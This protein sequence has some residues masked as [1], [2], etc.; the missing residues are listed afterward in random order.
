MPKLDTYKEGVK[1]RR[2]LAL[3]S[4]LSGSQL[5]S[6]TNQL[7][8]SL[9]FF[10]VHFSHLDLLI[11]FCFYLILKITG[12]PIV[13]QQVKNPTSIHK[14]AGSVLGLAQ[15]V[16]D[17][18]LPLAV[19]EVADA[20]PSGLAATVAQAGSYSSNS[21]PSLELPHAAGAALKRKK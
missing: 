14:D 20:A 21:T 9:T 8:N 16:K 2:S 19:V 5:T 10:L 4:V 17:P 18:A 1:T 12:V 13:A 11:Y 15:W 3:A 6:T 7:A